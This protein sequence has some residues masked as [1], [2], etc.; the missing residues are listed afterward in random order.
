MAGD[1]ESTGAV[2]RMEI[3]V[4]PLGTADSDITREVEQVLAAVESSGMPYQVTMTGTIIEGDPDS[5]F[6]LAR[7]MHEILFSTG[8]R[9]V[10]TSIRIDDRR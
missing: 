7:S 4:Y 3:A 2:A 5:L 6:A 1:Y 9:R 10:V 8:V